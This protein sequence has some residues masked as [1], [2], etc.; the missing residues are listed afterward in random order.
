MIICLSLF[1]ESELNTTSSAELKAQD[2]FISCMDEDSI[3]EKLGA[4]P[5]LDIINL[6]V[7]PSN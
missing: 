4:K 6:Q 3:I 5:L 7:S 2:F 1:T